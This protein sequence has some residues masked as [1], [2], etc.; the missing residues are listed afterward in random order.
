MGVNESNLRRRFLYIVGFPLFLFVIG[1]VIHEIFHFGINWIATGGH[2]NFCS[3]RYPFELKGWIPKTCLGYGGVPV[4]NRII[5][6]SV[7]ILLGVWLIYT[8]NRYHG[9]RGTSLLI[10]GILIWFFYSLYSISG[11]FWDP[12]V[13]NDSIYVYNNFGVVGLVPMIIASIIGFVMLVGRLKGS[14]E[15]NPHR[16]FW[17]RP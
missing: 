9:L 4:W 13:V 15:L 11:I 1:F 6:L 12:S 5:A 17:I 14:E 8:S 2:P 7:T 16:F 10:S 3:N